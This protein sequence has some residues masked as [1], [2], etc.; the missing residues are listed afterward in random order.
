[1]WTLFLE[2][3][4]RSLIAAVSVLCLFGLTGPVLAAP[5]AGPLVVNSASADSGVLVIRGAN[6]G[7]ITP[8][9]TLAGVP[10]VV[11]SSTQDEIQA[12]LPDPTPPGSYL[13][14]VARNPL[15]I[16][17][18][19]FDVTLGAAGPQGEQGPQ[20]EPGPQGEQGPPGPDVTAQIAALQAQVAD[21]NGRVAALEGKL[22][23]VS[24]AGNDITISGA[25]LYVNNG[26]GSTNTVNGLGNVIIGYNEPRGAGDDRSG[27][28]NLVVGSRNN[29]SSYGG[30][31]AGLQAGI[32][33]PFSIATS[34][35]GIALRTTSAFS[36]DAG[37]DIDLIASGSGELRANSTLDLRSSTTL[38]IN[39]PTVLIN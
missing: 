18:Y 37:T 33:T 10:L 23:H 1:L 31:V 27:S 30:L 11:L 35:D 21:L 32:A 20:G 24:V 6:F 36:L 19:L 14:F 16:P 4:M 39:A 12:L 17:F 25:N 28:H 7:N 8:Y 5:P 3:V 38:V 22:A 13:L 29:Y 26:I 34:G 9:V 15:R 2:G